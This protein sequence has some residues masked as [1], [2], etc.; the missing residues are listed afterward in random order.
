[1]VRVGHAEPWLAG[2]ISYPQVAGSI[3][4]KLASGLSLGRGD[5]FIPPGGTISSPQG[6][7]ISSLITYLIHRS[8]GMKFVVQEGSVG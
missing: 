5:R 1:M 3:I 6:G 2:R 8:T 4:R 7:T